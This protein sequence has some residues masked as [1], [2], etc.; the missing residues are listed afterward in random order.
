MKEP[1]VTPPAPP[2][3]TIEE[4]RKF[5]KENRPADRLL[6]EAKRSEEAG[7]RVAAD[8]LLKQAAK[9]GSAEAARKMGQRYDPV[10]YTPGGMIRNSN[11]EEAAEWYEKAAKAGD[12]DAMLR[13]AEMYGEGM[14]DRPD[15]AEQRLHWLR[16]AADA[17]SETA[18]ER[19]Q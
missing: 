13:L 16:K 9:G 12:V 7:A 19:L 14:L 17:G 6:E 5:L 4:A 1:P 2:I 15:A 8:M 3:T 10:T 11:A 18:K